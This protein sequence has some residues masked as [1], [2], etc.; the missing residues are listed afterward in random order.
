MQMTTEKYYI[1]HVILE[2]LEEELEI[3]QQEMINMQVM[4]YCLFQ[5]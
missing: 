3:S 2:S 1:W 4:M 5:E